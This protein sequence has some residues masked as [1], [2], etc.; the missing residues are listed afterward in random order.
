MQTADRVG[1]TRAV[2]N[3]DGRR[4]LSGYAVSPCVPAGSSRQSTFSRRNC[5][6]ASPS[7][8]HARCGPE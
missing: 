8:G 6:A 2:G 1:L 7:Y 5:S 3:S 4:D